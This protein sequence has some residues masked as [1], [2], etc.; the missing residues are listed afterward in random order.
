MTNCWHDHHNNIGEKENMLSDEHF[1]YK[2]S[3]VAKTTPISSTASSNL[4]S[5]ASSLITPSSPYN[6][7]SSTVDNDNDRH[8]DHSSIISD[9]GGTKRKRELG[10]ELERKLKL[11]TDEENSNTQEEDKH[12]T[13]EDWKWLESLLKE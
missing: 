3:E 2:E 8:I 7:P 1:N 11:R 6:T 12:I 10:M 5:L 9:Q 4:H 13:T